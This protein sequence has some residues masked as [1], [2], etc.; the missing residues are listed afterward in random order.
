LTTVISAPTCASRNA[1]NDCFTDTA[2]APFDLSLDDH[3]MSAPAAACVAGRAFDGVVINVEASTLSRLQS[4]CRFSISASFASAFSASA[5]LA[6]GVAVSAASGF[7]P[8]GTVWACACSTAARL[9]PA[10][11]NS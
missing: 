9:R 6:S 7:L 1:D 8:A 2:A 11:S 4:S 3:D 5:S 10:V